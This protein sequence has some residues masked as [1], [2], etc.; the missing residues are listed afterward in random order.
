[1]TSIASGLWVPSGNDYL[2]DGLWG[3]LGVQEE[4]GETYVSGSTNGLAIKETDDQVFLYAGASNGGVHLRIYD[5]ANDQWGDG[6]SWI[7]RPG[8]DYTGS[9]SIGVLSIS[10]DGQYL[11]VG[12]GNPSNYSFVGAPSHGVQIGAIQDDGSIQWLPVAEGAAEALHNQ[13]IRSMEWVGANLVAT[14]WDVYS[15]SGG[16]IEITTTPQGITAARTR[17]IDSNLTL[18]KGADVK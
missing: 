10:D 4:F 14:S 11:A 9:Q 1:M 5:K 8:G 12:Q 18:S 3:R 2:I 15:G 6:W 16:I 17:Q 13:N 7:S